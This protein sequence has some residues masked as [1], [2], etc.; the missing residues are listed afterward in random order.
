MHFRER[1]PSIQIIRTVYDPETKRARH[2]VV[3]RLSRAT[4]RLPDAVVDKLSAKEKAE[5]NAYIEHAKSVD[6]LRR[7]LTAHSLPQTVT[8]AVDYALGVEDE[9]ERDR[10]DVQFAEAMIQL[11]RAARRRKA[12]AG[13]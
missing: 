7:K 4:L 6:L 3:G 2:E 10:L 9:A 13:V 5:I 8:E 12:P 11:R 1:G